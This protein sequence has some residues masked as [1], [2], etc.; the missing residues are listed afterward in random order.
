MT[1]TCDQT[2]TEILPLDQST[3]RRVRH[4]IS[5]A[6]SMITTSSENLF[7]SHP[8]KVLAK[9]LLAAGEAK[10]RSAIDE[11]DASLRQ[12]S[13]YVETG[14]QVREVEENVNMEE[15]RLKVSDLIGTWK[16]ERFDLAE[17]DEAAHPWGYDMTGILIYAPTGYMS[18]AINRAAPWSADGNVASGVK[19][20]DRV[21]SYAGTYGI[22]DGVVHHRVMNASAWNR[23][24]T[25]LVRTPSKSG[26][27]LTLISKGDGFC[28]TLVWKRIG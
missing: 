27:T 28:A 8:D 10:I 7:G 24:G 5:T 22:E 3:T 11:L 4:K 21:L 17:D 9:K 2:D 20:S 23:I 25:D 19:D 13:T 12:G 26:D 6:C 15:D 14:N 18:V 1:M 16:L